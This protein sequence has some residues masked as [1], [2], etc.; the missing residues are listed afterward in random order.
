[1]L[2]FMM[3]SSIGPTTPQAARCWAALPWWVGGALI[4]TGLQCW[5][6]PPPKSRQRFNALALAHG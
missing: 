3:S 4:K 6:A 5:A 1:V 2:I